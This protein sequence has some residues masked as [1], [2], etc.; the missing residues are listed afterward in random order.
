MTESVVVVT[1]AGRGIGG[2]IARSLA[3]DGARVVLAGRTASSLESVR[4]AIEADGGTALVHPT[5]VTDEASVA[6]LFA[7]A[8]ETFGR[9]DVLV[10]NAGVGAHTEL[11]DLTA[12][13]WEQVFATNVRGM[14]LCSR[15]AGRR[16]HEAGAGRAIN[17]ASVFG[18]V[19]RSGFAAYSASKGAV[20]SFTRSVAV[21]WARVGAQMNTVAPG[22]IATDIN[23]ELRAD[24]ALYKHVLRGIP[25]GR[26]GTVEEIAGVVTYLSL[27]APDFLT[28]QTIAVDGGESSV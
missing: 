24:T 23:A 18:L 16:F 14:F 9:V 27:Y 28:G 15:E 6:S 21:E 8:D 2:C 19:G 25:A 1:G 13:D 11:Q 22:L 4:T 12:S 17:I 7:A 5:D 26:M 20:I 10:N 3:K